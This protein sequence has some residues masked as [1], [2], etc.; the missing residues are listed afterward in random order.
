MGPRTG[1]RRSNPDDAASVAAVVEELAPGTGGDRPPSRLADAV[2]D[3]LDRA[4]EEAAIHAPRVVGTGGDHPHEGA[5]VRIAE[6]TRHPVGHHDVRVAPPRTAIVVEP[7]SPFLTPDRSGGR[8][9]LAT[10]G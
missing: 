8:G 7:H 3:E 10:G 9:G 1:R 4:V 5:D 2:L 6:E